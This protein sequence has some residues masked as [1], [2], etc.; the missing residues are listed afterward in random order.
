MVHRCALSAVGALLMA[1]SGGFAAGTPSPA[2]LVL[3]KEGAL[4]IVDPATREV[5]ARVRTGDDPHEVATSADGRLAFVSNYGSG[6]NPGH[7]LSVIDLVA[8]KELHRVDLAPLSRPHGLDFAGG[9]L[10]FTC[11]AN[12]AIGRYDPVANAVDLILG[13]GQNTTHMVRVSPSLDRIYTANI[14]SDS[15]SVFT[16]NGLDWLPEVIP[17][18]KGPEGFDLTPDGKELWAANSR[19]GSVSVVNLAERRVTHTFRVDTKRSNRLKFTPDGKLALIT[20]LDGGDLLIYD[21]ATLRQLKRIPLGRQPAGIL[22]EPGGA[23]AYVAVTGDDFVAVI[24][25]K[26]LELSARIQP[27]SG[28]DGMAWAVRH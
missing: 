19:S 3:D 18:G 23:R 2:L 6:T 20:D 26:S 28:P 25:L 9:K 8:Q 12:K 1:A 27:G 17:V 13:T 10:Y 24:D 7:T 5:V 22:V 16:R 21:H 15:V 14:G 4:A 11:E